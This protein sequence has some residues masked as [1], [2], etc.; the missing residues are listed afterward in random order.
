MINSRTSLKKTLVF[1][2]GFFST[3]ELVQLFGITIF[4][5][6]MVAFPFYMIA[7]EKKFYFIKNNYM[8]TYL[9][10]VTISESL[11][12]TIQLENKQIWISSSLKKY[13]LLLFLIISLTYI[14]NMRNGKQMF[15]NGLYYSCLLEMVWCYLQLGCYKLTGFDINMAFFGVSHMNK[16][17]GKL[18][19]SGLNSNA[20]ILA[21]ALFFLILFDKRYT[22][23]LLSVAVFFISGTSTMIICG[24]V[25]VFMIT[26]HYI[27][28]KKN[29]GKYTVKQKAMK[30]L[31]ASFLLILILFTLQ[32]DLVQNLTNNFIRLFN[33][34]KDA[35]DSNFSDGSTFAHTRYYTSILYVWANSN[36]LNIVFGN[37]IGCA[38]VPFVRLFNQYAE[39]V[40][41]PESD[42]IT[43]L[44]NYGIVGFTY[45]YW[46]IINVIIKG[47]KVSWKYPTFYF[48]VIV[49]GIFYGMFLNWVLLVTWLS[50]S[51]LKEQKGRLEKQKI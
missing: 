8:W 13:I 14:A 18:I 40:Y 24:M 31:L 41:V 48:S 49:G 27:Y 23:K 43:F 47:K 12:A 15:F 29:M 25:I 9:I 32:P 44:Y 33:R 2:C 26:I 21:P 39:L 16:A 50:I 7:S 28:S 45:I 34:L 10:I 22:I 5:W 37:G 35:I 36:L 6:L 20:G 51:S 3:F 19:L 17:N 38:G 1:L 4:S 46:L 30:V 11:T 42:P